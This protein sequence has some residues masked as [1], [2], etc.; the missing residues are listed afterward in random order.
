[1]RWALTFNNRRLWYSL[2]AFLILVAIGSILI[3]SDRRES[4]VPQRPPHEKHPSSLLLPENGCV[5]DETTATRIAEA[6]WLAAYGETIYHEK[7]FRAEL[8][9]D[10]VWAVAGSL[11]TNMLGGVPYIEIRK[12]DGRI[13]G[14]GY[15]K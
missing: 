15:G 4:T 3:M 9:G 14:I 1:M 7:P 10:S 12:E 5:P 8:L 2:A 6:V 13:L 11:P